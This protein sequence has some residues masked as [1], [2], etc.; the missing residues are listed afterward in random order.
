MN[1]TLRIGR[2][3]PNAMEWA[4]KCE[5]WEVQVIY[6]CHVSP[7]QSF[8]NYEAQTSLYLAINKFDIERR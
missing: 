8:M 6:C 2:N 1:T 7:D 4:T 3:D 5:R